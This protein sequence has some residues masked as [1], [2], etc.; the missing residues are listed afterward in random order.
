M[1]IAHRGLMVRVMGAVKAVSP[2]LI[3]GS[4]LFHTLLP[5]FFSICNVKFGSKFADV[6]ANKSV[7]FC[8]MRP[9]H[10]W[11]GSFSVFC[12]EVSLCRFLL[13]ILLSDWSLEDSGIYIC[14][15]LLCY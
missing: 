6:S 13:V 5:V 10:G 15:Q 2:T 14:S 4:F 3:E 12:A 1:T 7:F 8:S 9:N 11:F